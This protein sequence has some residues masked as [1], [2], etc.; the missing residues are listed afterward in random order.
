[1]KNSQE[2]FSEDSDNDS[3]CYLTENVR[4]NYTGKP[5]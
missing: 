3:R 1:M 2:K 4:E 5:Y